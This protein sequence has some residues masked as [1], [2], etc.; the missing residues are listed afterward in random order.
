MPIKLTAV[1]LI[2]LSIQER[3]DVN[4]HHA[5]LIEATQMTYEDLYTA[6]KHGKV[7]SSI[8]S[9]YYEYQIQ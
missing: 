8:V 4:L 5:S 9:D 6:Y 1:I 3:K 2:L 7:I